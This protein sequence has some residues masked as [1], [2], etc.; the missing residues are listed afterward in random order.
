MTP[1]DYMD[2]AYALATVEDQ[3]IRVLAEMLRDQMTGGPVTDAAVG[4]QEHAATRAGELRRK[5][6][7]AVPLSIAGRPCA[8]CMDQRELHRPGHDYE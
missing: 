5:A 4:A 8:D 7:M 2:M 6:V 3:R 1:Q